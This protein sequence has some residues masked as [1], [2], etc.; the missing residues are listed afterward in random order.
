L[1]EGQV[2]SWWCCYPLEDE[3]EK[4]EDKQEESEEEKEQVRTKASNH[5]IM[6]D[7]IF[8]ILNFL[9]SMLHLL[10]NCYYI[11][12]YRFCIWH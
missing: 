10:Q 1:D 11:F 9:R 7:L 8:F 5:K 12:Y 4:G 6:A 2:R 3:R